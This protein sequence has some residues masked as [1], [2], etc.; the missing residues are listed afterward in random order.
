MRKNFASARRFLRVAH[1]GASGLAP[2]NTLAAFEL[3]LRLG[4]DALETD[5]R[6]CRDAI[7]AIHDAT[8]ERTTSGRGHVSDFT[9]AELKHLDAGAGQRLP[10]LHEVLDLGEKHSVH[11]FLEVKAHGSPDGDWVEQIAARVARR[12][13]L[14]QV[15]FISFDVD[16]LARIKTA[17]P[18]ART[19]W[20]LSR[21][22]RAPWDQLKNFGAAV[23]APR[24]NLLTAKRVAEAH[25][26]GLQVMVWTVDDL[27]AMRRLIA[28][29]V[30]ALATNFPD[31]LNAALGR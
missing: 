19:G 12:R 23:I 24:W 2:E 3:A 30:D 5:L 8:L 26:R 31:R 6:P 1:R 21:W 17:E 14:E 20:L 9:L 4:T 13:Q 16:A 22:R 29:G 10:A 11:L 27:A 28:V 25:K 7:V 18:G 15:T